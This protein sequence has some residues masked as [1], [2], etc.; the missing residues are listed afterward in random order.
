MAMLEKLK[1]ALDRAGVHYEVH[2]HK[3]AFTAP[4]IAAS[5]HIPGREMAKVVI[6]KTDATFAMAVLN[7]NGRVDL[8]LAKKALGKNARLATEQELATL[9][10]G[11]E[12]GAMPPFGNLYGI[13]VFADPILDG[14]ESI[15][16]N[17]GNHR[18]TVK[19]RYEDWK[20]LVQPKMVALAEEPARAA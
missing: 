14:D 18:E 2:Q 1:D 7:A 6:L 16:F 20:S 13:P 10:P 8:S 5:E 3:E 19:M 12:T 17:A 11:C 4:E 9:F 15:H